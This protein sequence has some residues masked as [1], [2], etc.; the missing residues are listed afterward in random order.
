M[1]KAMHKD[2]TQFMDKVDFIAHVAGRKLLLAACK[3]PC[4]E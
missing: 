2:T 4:P 3:A 1:N